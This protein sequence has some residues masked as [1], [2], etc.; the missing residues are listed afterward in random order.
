[1]LCQ[2]LFGQVYLTESVYNVVLRKSI[3]AQIR[4]LILCMRNNQGQDDG[5][6]RELTFAKRLYEHST[7]NKCVWGTPEE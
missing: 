2:G 5:F 6:V 4:Q 1:M 7:W 3:P